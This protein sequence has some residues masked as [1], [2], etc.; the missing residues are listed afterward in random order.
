M[1]FCM[2]L[3]LDGDGRA[4]GRMLHGVGEHIFEGLSQAVGIC[5]DGELGRRLHLDPHVWRLEQTGDVLEEGGKVK[6]LPG[7]FRTMHFEN[8]RGLPE[9]GEVEGECAT[10]TGRGTGRRGTRVD[11]ARMASQGRKPAVSQV[12][13]VEDWR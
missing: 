8:G 13:P 3:S 12:P 7:G 4:F 11:Q 5:I 6:L 10:V 2:H 1:V 9:V